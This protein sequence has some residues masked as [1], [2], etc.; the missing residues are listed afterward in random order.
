ME[1]TS[2]HQHLNEANKTYFMAGIFLSSLEKNVQI[3]S[4]KMYSI[5]F[6]DFNGMDFA[7]IHR[8]AR[9]FP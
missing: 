8:F 6:A 5:L 2:T 1:T 4:M 9:H 3:N 7:R